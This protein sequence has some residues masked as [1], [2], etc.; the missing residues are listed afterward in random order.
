[1]NLH[2]AVLIAYSAMLILFGLWIGRLV[3]TSSDFFVAGRSLS[4]TL[5]FATVMAANLGA[6]TTVGAA[7]LGY[8][9]G[10]SAWWWVGSAAIGT[11]FLA[12]WVGP[13]IHRMAA[14][15]GFYTV[16]DFLER[17]YGTL[18]R[19]AMTS[20]LWVGT[21]AILAGQLIALSVVLEVVVGFPRTP[22]LL[23]GGIVTTT[24]FTAG[25]LRGAAWINLVQLVVLLVGFTLA[26]VLGL[27]VAEGWS[28]LHAVGP[29][30]G[31]RYFNF[32][33]GGGAGWMLM[34][35]L[36]PNFIVSPG[37]LQK[38]YGARDTRSIKL[39]VGICAVGLLVFAFAPAVLGM[40]ARLQHPELANPDHALP[41]LL[42]SDLPLI[43]G[44][45]GLGALFVADI[46]SADAI[47]FMLATSM[48]Q[49]LYR[50]FINPDASDRRVLLVAR[51]AAVLGGVVAVGMAIVSPSVVTPLRFFYS[52]VGLSFFVPVIAGL[53]TGRGGAPEVFASILAGIATTLSVHLATDGAGIGA[54]T[55]NFLGLLTASL[56]FLLVVWGRARGRAGPE[57]K[58]SETQ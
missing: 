41:M 13:R 11:F 22:A 25:G 14:E 39:G 8:Q 57:A 18:V 26:V 45:I 6:G 55:P 58:T 33:N 23:L 16:G 21:P 24:Y 19:G 1:M 48:S 46:S 34:A 44:A 56:G 10:L 5:L 7:S 17:R 3:R 28:G 49:D 47:L 2:L 31:D 43:V 42:R 52:L 32:W 36:V 20:L 35:L 51:L 30:V 53:Y 38:I 54:L 50:R 4:P 40:I 37:L 27:Q 9:F 15:H 29:S 12:F